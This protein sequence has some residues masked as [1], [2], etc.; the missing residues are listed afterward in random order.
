[1][2]MSTDTERLD[3]A[4]A[5]HDDDPAR[6]AA[7]LRAINAAQLAS[8][9][10]PGYA[11]L[12]NHVLGEKGGHWDEALQRQRALLALAQPAPALVLWRQAATA[13]RLADAEPAARKTEQTSAVAAE[14]AAAFAQ[15]SGASLERSIELLQLNAVM[16]QVP[17]LA[18]AQV[19]QPVL[20]ALAPFA[21]PSWQ[22]NGP[23]DASVAAC[24]NN[25]ASGI[26]DR[27]GADLQHAELRSAL[28][29]STELALRF[30][31]RAGSWVQHERALYL[32][33][34]VSNALAEHAEARAY[35]Q[36]ALALLDQHD[37]A[38]AED[39]DR[40]FIELERWHA[41]TRSGLPA[42]AA[43]AR[44]KADALAARFNDAG[45]TTWF[46]QREKTLRALPLR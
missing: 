29:Q 40:A 27:P 20:A 30:W 13:A 2:T 17:S 42:E 41:C 16:Y 10:W 36:V 22:A 7:L 12:L 32:C 21:L 28:A 45:L 5:C 25:I 26:L 24:L 38:H 18:S 11:F 34:M 19:A 14:L 1:M 33:A 37:T 43:N 31:Q 15:A 9:R 3:E 8:D 39:V 4:N 46:E 6:G 23:L 35:A 44:T